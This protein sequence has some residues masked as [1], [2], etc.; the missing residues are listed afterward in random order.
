[1]SRQILIFDIWGDYAH[2][3]KIYAT[4]SAVSYAIPPKTSL[5]GYM[6][7]ILGLSKADNAYL[8]A[9]ADKQC[10]VGLSV[11]N[12]I[13]MKRLGINLRPNLKRT[14]NNPK[15][16]LLEY[17]YRPGYRLYVS[18]QDRRV[19]DALRSALIAHRSV[20]TPS[21]GLAGLVSNFAWVGEVTASA[22][23][24]DVAIPIHSVIPRKYFLAFDEEALLAGETELIEQSL[25]AIEMNT[26]RDVTERDDIL[27]ERKGKPIQARVTEYYSVNGTNIILF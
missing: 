6:G 18:H 15:P 25:F 2:Y 1:M 4:T 23:R 13:V 10:L 8:T 19:Q 20:F 17:V 12:P 11:L 22:S 9:F 27:L 3:K 26:E 16:T 7:A 24:T 5:Y 14:A 21:M